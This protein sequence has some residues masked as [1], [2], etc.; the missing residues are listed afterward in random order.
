MAL[1]LEKKAYEKKIDLV[2]EKATEKLE[3]LLLLDSEEIQKKPRE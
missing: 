2:L 1:T 3:G